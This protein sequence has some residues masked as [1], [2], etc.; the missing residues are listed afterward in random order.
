M[1]L[2]TVMALLFGSLATI[3]NSALVGYLSS[4]LPS[5]TNLL[6]KLDILLVTNMTCYT[7]VWVS[8]YIGGGTF[9]SYWITL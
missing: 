9:V 8:K 3:N 6:T 2:K 1:V 4:L 7:Y 5:Q